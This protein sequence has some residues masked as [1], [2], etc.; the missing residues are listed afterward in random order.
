MKLQL[1]KTK[2]QMLLE[3]VEVIDTILEC[4]LI[5]QMQWKELAMKITTNMDGP[6]VQNGG[7]RSKMADAVDK[8][9][10][11]E[12][13]IAGYVDELIK[14]KGEAVQTM[15]QLYSPTEYKILHMRYIQHIKLQ[16]IAD[17]LDKEYTWVTTTHGRALKN[18]DA[19]MKEKVCDL[20]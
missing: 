16:D 15:E 18:L 12:S 10:D 1:K 6:P 4:K 8:C 20:V 2:A 19:I 3:R 13:E 17:I 7:T 9:I 14:K 11:M 5:E